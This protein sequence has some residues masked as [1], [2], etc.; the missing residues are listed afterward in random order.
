MVR[1]KRWTAL[2]LLPLFLPAAPAC[3]Q[4]VPANGILLVARPGMGDPRFRET[5]VLV[6]Q[7]QDSTTVGVILNKPMQEKLADL[8]PGSAPA[9]SYPDP[10]F[11]G[12]PVM[13]RS[14]VA[15]FKS[16]EVPVGAAFHVHRR[17]YLSMHPAVVE[18]L[19]ASPGPRLRLFAGFSGWA[20]RQLQGEMGRSDWF[21]LPVTEELLFRKSTA[22]MWEELL[23]RAT[24]KDGGKRAAL[25]WPA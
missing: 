15:L 7:A 25:Y 21:V 4:A 14:I 6:T 9:R 17:I 19:L 22:G 3:A 20:P 11:F 16:D 8:R 10:V 2:L 24:G 12:G 5:V 23:E 13:Q 18:P 1:M